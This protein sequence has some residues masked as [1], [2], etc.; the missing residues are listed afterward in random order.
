MKEVD[1]IYLD[2]AIY[3]NMA[4]GI[5]V[6]NHNILG[7]LTKYGIHFQSYLRYTVYIFFQIWECYDSDLFQFLTLWDDSRKRLRAT[8]YLLSDIMSRYVVSICLF[9]ESRSLVLL[10]AESVH[11]VALLGEHDTQFEHICV[12]SLHTIWSEYG[13][14]ANFLLQSTG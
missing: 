14:H 2:S 10:G 12:S 5:F 6:L 13:L 7:K 1:Q 9:E 4:L 8:L 11:I 3:N